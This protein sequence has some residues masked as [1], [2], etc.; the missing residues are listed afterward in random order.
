MG[1]VQFCSICLLSRHSQAESQAWKLT[2]ESYVCSITWK[3][4]LSFE[5]NGT[6]ISFRSRPQWLKHYRNLCLAEESLKRLLSPKLF[7]PTLR[8][9]EH[10]QQA[11]M[12]AM[13]YVG[14]P[15]L[16]ARQE[17]R[18]LAQH[19]CCGNEHR[20]LHVSRFSVT[21]FVGKERGGILSRPGL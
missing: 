2:C 10:R 19:K 11:L 9:S 4:L 1:Y 8:P 6:R 18:W 17:M 16:P 20:L 12:A 7:R 5:N 15:S 21:V 3:S 13:E 14:Q